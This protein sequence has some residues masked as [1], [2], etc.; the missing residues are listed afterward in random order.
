MASFQYTNILQS[1]TMFVFQNV[2]VK[3]V[4]KKYRIPAQLLIFASFNVHLNEKRYA[5][6]LACVVSSFG[7]ER[8][9]KNPHLEAG[10]IVCE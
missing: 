10:N 8:A 4:H 3:L 2:C 9:L 6:P 5:Y 7:A 1:K